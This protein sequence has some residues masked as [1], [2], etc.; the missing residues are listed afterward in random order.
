MTH[1]EW[2]LLAMAVEVT[3]MAL[4]RGRPVPASR[5]CTGAN[6]FAATKFRTPRR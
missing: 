4:G 1:D 6:L 5:R 3:S 2:S